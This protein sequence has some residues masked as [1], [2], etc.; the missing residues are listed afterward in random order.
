MITSNDAK[1][2]LK[3]ELTTK[4]KPYEYLPMKTGVALSKKFNHDSSYL[5][6]QITNHFDGKNIYAWV[7]F[8]YD[9]IENIIADLNPINISNKINTPTLHSEMHTFVGKEMKIYSISEFSELKISTTCIYDF[10]IDPVIPFINNISD[11]EFAFS[12]IKNSN[13]RNIFAGAGSIRAMKITTMAHVI[14]DIKYRDKI[15]D[16]YLI[17]FELYNNDSLIEYKK[18]IDKLI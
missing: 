14:G 6:I 9:G 3:E 2:Y 16:E 7:S 1:K 5:D 17:K 15:I 13:N 4:L 12:L 8:R 18:F 11:M 10:F